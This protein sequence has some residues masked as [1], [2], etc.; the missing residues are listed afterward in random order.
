MSK[1]IKL[2]ILKKHSSWFMNYISI[3]ALKKKKSWLGSQIMA[4]AHYRRFC[5]KAFS[6][7]PR[8]CHPEKTPPPPPGL[9][10]SMIG[11]HTAPLMST[12]EGQ[13]EVPNFHP[14]QLGDP[15]GV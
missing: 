14:S 2:Y 7:E 4:S 5:T 8:A 3:K 9:N 15:Q 13:N 10:S 12:K 11:G 6:K 1:L